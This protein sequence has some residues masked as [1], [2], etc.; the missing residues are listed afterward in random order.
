M[1]PDVINLK[2]RTIAITRPADQ[3]EETAQ[4][5]TSYGGVPYFV[6][7]IEIKQSCDLD[8][9]KRFVSEL[10]KNRIDYV[11]F[12]SVN[13]IRYLVSC[14]E[15]LDLK[16]EL[17]EGLNKVVV[18][19]VGPKTAQELVEYDVLVNLVPAQYSSE[20]IIDCLK[21]Q[22]VVGKTVFIPR[23]KGAPPDLA[24][25]LRNLGAVV[26]ELYVYESLLPNEQSLNQKVVE[27]LRDGAIDAIVFGSSLSAKNLFGM[28]KDVIS[29]KQLQTLLNT[30]LTI[31]AIGPT[32]AQALSGLGLHVDVMPK[33]YLFLETLKAL[34]DFWGT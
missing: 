5:I 15:S 14:A 6:P 24:N 19:A 33:K 1:V 8:S 25:N 18:L 2:G 32:T 23:T 22:D 21:K 26:C 20:G 3:A 16:L 12:M 10:E 34:S 9:V 17:L 30:Q 31:V 28:L 11:L 27:D 13:G 4:L 7:S 29:Q